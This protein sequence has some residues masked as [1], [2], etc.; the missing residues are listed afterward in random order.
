M[1]RR[2]NEL[3]GR[4][5]DTRPHVARKELLLCGVVNAY[6][7]GGGGEGN[8]ACEWILKADDVVLVVDK[9]NGDASRCGV[10]WVKWAE[11]CRR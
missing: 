3:W 10:K 11:G 2:P 9:S 6:I 8:K 1:N 5:H 7:E 4:A